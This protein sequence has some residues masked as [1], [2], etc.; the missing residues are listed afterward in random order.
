MGPFF[1]GQVNE[2]E[3]GF[4]LLISKNMLLSAKGRY[5][6]SYMWEPAVDWRQLFPLGRF[7]HDSFIRHSSGKLNSEMEEWK[8]NLFYSVIYL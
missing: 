7:G 3:T 6:K 8:K 2:I 4:E 1:K 5:L